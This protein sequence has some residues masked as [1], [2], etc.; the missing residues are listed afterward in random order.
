MRCGEAGL[1]DLAS[2]QNQPSPTSMAF[3]DTPP[4]GHDAA[5]TTDTDDHEA[6]KK[7]MYEAE[8]LDVYASDFTRCWWA[9]PTFMLQ[10]L[11]GLESRDTCEVEVMVG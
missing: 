9:R 6:E 11:M 10:V 3:I 1:L 7:G 4:G 2:T 5:Q 8:K